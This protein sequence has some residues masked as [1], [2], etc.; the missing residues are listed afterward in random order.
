[1]LIDLTNRWHVVHQPYFIIMKTQ[2]LVFEKKIQ[3]NI[4]K[5]YFVLYNNIVRKEGYIWAIF[6][7]VRELKS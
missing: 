1:M 7:L 5:N 6:Y 2:Y 4:D 3:L